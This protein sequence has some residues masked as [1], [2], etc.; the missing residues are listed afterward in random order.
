MQA[1]GEIVREKTG[2]GKGEAEAEGEEAVGDTHKV[3][4]GRPFGIV[5]DGIENQGTH[6][7]PVHENECGLRWVADGICIDLSPVSRYDYLAFRTSRHRNRHLLV[8]VFV[9]V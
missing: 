4:L 2:R 5:E 8:L 3:Y 9:F 7:E 6:G 1:R